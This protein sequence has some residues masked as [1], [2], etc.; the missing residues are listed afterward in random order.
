MM[1]GI[2]FT[3]CREHHIQ[4]RYRRHEKHLILILPPFHPV[5]INLICTSP[6]SAVIFRS[7]TWNFGPASTSPPSSRQLRSPRATAP[8][9]LPRVHSAAV[10]VASSSSGSLFLHTVK[11]YLLQI[12]CSLTA[13][14]GPNTSCTKHISRGWARK[15]ESACNAKVIFIALIHKLRVWVW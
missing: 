7:L 5:L 13:I 15:G 9:Q 4:E 6:K 3:V 1:P 8:L 14:H 2:R 11:V 10:A 12:F